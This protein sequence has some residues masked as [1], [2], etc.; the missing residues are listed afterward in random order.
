[1]QDDDL[2]AHER[3]AMTVVSALL[4]YMVQYVCCLSGCG[5]DEQED[6]YCDHG[7]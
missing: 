3:G 7:S 2:G 6:N 1:M 4:G 5:E